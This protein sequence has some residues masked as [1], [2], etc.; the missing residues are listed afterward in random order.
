MIDVIPK[1]E[2]PILARDGG[3]ITPDFLGVLACCRGDVLGLG[4]CCN[5]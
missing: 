1:F 2:V 3:Q 4:I 5:L